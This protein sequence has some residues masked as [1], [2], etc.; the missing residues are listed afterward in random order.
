MIDHVILSVSDFERS[1]DFYNNAMKPLGISMI[2]DFKGPGAHPDL[3]GFGDAKAIY[4]WLKQGNP[5]PGGV[6]VGFIAK[7]NAQVELFH[8]AAISAGAKNIESPRVFTEYYP[9]YYAAWILDPDG[10]EIELAHKS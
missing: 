6:H 4:F 2:H 3:K 7:D 10:Y 5:T 1:I 9:G 8:E